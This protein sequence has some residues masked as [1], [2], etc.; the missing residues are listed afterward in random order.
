MYIGIAETPFA[1]NPPGFPCSRPVARIHCGHGSGRRIQPR[2]LRYVGHAGSRKVAQPSRFAQIHRWRRN[3][4][5]QMKLCLLLGRRATQ[6]RPAPKRA[7]LAFT[8]AYEKLSSCG[9]FHGANNRRRTSRDANAQRGGRQSK[10]RSFTHKGNATVPRRTLPPPEH[11]R[12]AFSCLRY[13]CS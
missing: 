8:N 1:K 12:V 4:L 3:L 11:D 2:S 6:L 13:P 10:R 7:S 5:S 9:Y